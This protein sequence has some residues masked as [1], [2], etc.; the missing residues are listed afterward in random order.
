MLIECVGLTV[1]YVFFV[2]SNFPHILVYH[3]S[4]HNNSTEGK[5]I[6][7]TQNV[8]LMYLIFVFVS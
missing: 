5:K 8:I 7:A 4:Y 1:L 6:F 3:I 2:I